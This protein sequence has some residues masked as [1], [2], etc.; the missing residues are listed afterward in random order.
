M[1]RFSEKEKERIKQKLLT[2]GEHLFTAYGLKKVTIDDLVAAANIAKAS[3]YKFYD[4]KEYLYLD[5]VETAQADIF[6]SL[7]KVLDENKAYSAGERVKQVFLKMYE[8]MLKY[9]ILS[10]INAANIEMISR[11]VSEQRLAEFTEQNVDAVNVLVR[12]GIPFVYDTKTVSTVFGALYGA[13]ISLPDE[14]DRR[15]KQVIDIMLSGIIE[16]IVVSE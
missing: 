14:G 1:P 9:P 12:H 3:F 4:G 7:E 10:Q 15:K 6:T 2:E 5:I 16:Q 13:W 11:K 8:L